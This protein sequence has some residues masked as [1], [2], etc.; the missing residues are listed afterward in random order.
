VT[1]AAQVETPL[2][3]E[4]DLDYVMPIEGHRR[5]R[6]GAE[7]ASLPSECSE[8]GLALRF[9]DLHADDLRFTAEWNH[10]HRRQGSRWAKDR[11][12][13]VFA[14]VRKLCRE[15]AASLSDRRARNVIESA[16][17]VAAVEKLAR[18]D[19]RH[20]A[21]P[22]QWDADPF[23][24]C[25]PGGIVDLQLG[26]MRPAQSED[27]HTKQTAVSPSSAKCPRWIEFLKWITDGDS[28]YMGFLQRTLGY[29]VT[30]DTREQAL[31]FVYGVGGNGKGVTTS[32][33]TG[34]LNDYAAVAPMEAF[35]ESRGDRHPTEIAMLRGARFVHAQET[36]QG[37]RW[38]ESRIKALTGGDRISARYM[39]QDFFEF[40]PQFKL[41]IAGNH[42]PAL[43]SV[44]EAIRRRFYLLPFPR[45]ISADKKDDLL[46]D[47][48]REE[49]P[50]I[51]GWI[52]EGTSRWLEQ[53]LRPPSCVLDATQ[54][55]FAEQDSF[56]AWITECC[57]AKNGAWESSANLY[58]SWS[59][60]AE[61]AGEK[62][63]TMKSFSD[64]LQK[65]GFL[66]KQSG[67]SKT[68]GYEGLS[69]R[70]D[71]ANAYRD[72]TS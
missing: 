21:V 13:D 59:V 19:K 35:T 10:W 31:F 33:V 22:E 61:H 58:R 14:R 7:A 70:S 28:A 53:G 68:R 1:T 71:T 39:R 64:Q 40:V 23:A 42:K 32:T 25:T 29:C 50:A 55:Y 45:V 37:R 24:L 16:H 12:L 18:F 8:D 30:G 38:A 69:V 56:D 43:S 49:W 17:T 26:V 66:P 6:G 3:S 62:A 20:A 44:D 15:S 65:K 9:S 52:I 60:W 5:R 34:I 54:Q 4:E 51:L 67:H 27:Y 57:S 63:G 2:L 47:R 36:E 72:G 46:A 41:F 48:L 11:T